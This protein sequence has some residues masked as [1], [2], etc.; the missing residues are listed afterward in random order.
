MIPEPGLQNSIP[1]FLAALSKKSKTSWLEAIEL[2]IQSTDGCI[3]LSGTIRLITVP[4][5]LHPHPLKPGSDG[6]NG[7][8]W[9]QL[10]YQAQHS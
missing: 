1:Y 5:G 6:R 3:H 2:C 8:W 9:E 7:Y 10:S 4:L